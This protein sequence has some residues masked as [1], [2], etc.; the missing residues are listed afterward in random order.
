MLRG[1][2]FLVSVSLCLVCLTAA[3]ARNCS[4]DLQ[5]NVGKLLMKAK[6][7]KSLECELYTP[8]VDQYK[9]CSQSTMNCLINEINVLFLE[10][11]AADL[12]N[13][14]KHKTAMF[15][16]L[17][18]FGEMI[19]ERDCPK[20]ESLEVENAETFLAG[21]QSIL[22]FMCTISFKAGRNEASFWRRNLI[23]TQ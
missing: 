7:L 4:I 1:A 6:E 19:P 5:T 13:I 15:S 21:L 16:I 14:S 20:C 18:S 12:S 9:N 3:P 10:W 22:Q 2:L 23:G 11:E 8:T 17:D